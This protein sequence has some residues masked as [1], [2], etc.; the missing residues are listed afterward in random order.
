MILPVSYKPSLLVAK[1]SR[2]SPAKVRIVGTFA[3]RH[4]TSHNFI[5]RYVNISLPT[6]ETSILSITNYFLGAIV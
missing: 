4:F 6:I 1:A 2:A 5:V 3:V